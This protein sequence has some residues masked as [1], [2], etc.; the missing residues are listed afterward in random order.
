MTRCGLLLEDGYSTY[1]SSLAQKKTQGGHGMQESA[2]LHAG[3]TN[4]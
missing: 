3:P 4:Q 2:T 1:V